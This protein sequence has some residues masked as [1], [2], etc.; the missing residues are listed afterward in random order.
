MSYEIIQYMQVIIFYNGYID[1]C[2]YLVDI[3]TML[4]SMRSTKM[5]SSFQ[6]KDDNGFRNKRLYV[7]VLTYLFSSSSISV[8]S[9]VTSPL[10][11]MSRVQ[12]ANTLIFFCIVGRFAK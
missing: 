7:L 6:Y 10:K 1:G 2:E 9:I 3:K 8:L 12:S 11:N 5:K 4:I